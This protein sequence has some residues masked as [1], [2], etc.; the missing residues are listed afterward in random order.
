MASFSDLPNSG[1]NSI[2]L[3]YNQYVFNNLVSY[4]GLF[5]FFQKVQCLIVF[6][7]GK[8]HNLLRMSR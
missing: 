3:K 8:F 4:Q 7:D 5:A 6:L 2:L 1:A